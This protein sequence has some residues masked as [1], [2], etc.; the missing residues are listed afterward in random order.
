MTEVRLSSP[1][2]WQSCS[3]AVTRIGSLPFSDPAAAIDFVAAACPRLPF[4]PQPPAANL[5]EVTLGQFN[6]PE[7][8]QQTTLHRFTQAALA[9]AFQRHWRS[10][11]R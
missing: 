9:G 1:E 10:R 6:E 3:G 2:W 4:C 5:V 11:P 8:G 7:S